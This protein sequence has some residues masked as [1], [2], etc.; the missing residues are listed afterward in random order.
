MAKKKQE[1]PPTKPE[2][3]KKIEISSRNILSWAVFVPTV[4]IVFISLIPVVFPALITRTTSPLQSEGYHANVIDPFQTGELAAPLIITN[5]I[6]LAIAIW[7]YK[8]SKIQERFRS[9][10]SFEVSKKQA[11]VAV[12]AIL[13][14]FSGIT[15]GTLGTQEIWTDFQNVKNRVGGWSPSQFGSTFEPH[16]KY[17]FLWVSQNAFG[18]MRILPFLISLALL[19]QTYFFTKDITG[20][21][22]A[23]IVSMI[24][25]LQ[26]DIF[27]N[28]STTA[29][30]DNSWILL[31]LFSLYLVQKFWPPSPVPY[32]LSIF[33]KALTIAFLPMSLYFI[34]RSSISKKSRI[35]SLVSY[36]IILIIIAVAAT[37]YKSSL[38]AGT[39][40]FDPARFWQG[41][42]SMAIQMRFDYIVVLFLL[43]VT[44]LLFFQSRKEILHADSML[45]FIL[46]ILLAAP[47]LTG[48]TE[49]TNQPYRFVSLSVFFAI[50]IGVL[51]S[52]KTRKGSELSS[53]T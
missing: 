15:V 53:S 7:Y 52:N 22:L 14:I 16:T 17:F 44:V 10:T 41:F 18:N 42:A 29:S 46:V 51:L 30:Y 5:V 3:K 11:L 50:G 20:R 49:Q 37:K 35:Y 43:P 12:L 38:A 47:F 2:P 21:R 36:G 6:V 34:A 8:R 9:I 1:R 28:Y 31:F 24:L 27:V 45:V 4:T 39:I 40:A 33:A 26:S 48:F 13:V 19:V 23:G 32:F 25:V